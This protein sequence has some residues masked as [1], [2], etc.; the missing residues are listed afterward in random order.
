MAHCSGLFSFQMMNSGTGSYALGFFIVPMGEEL[1]ISRKKVLSN[2]PFQVSHNPHITNTRYDGRPKIRCTTHSYKR[3]SVRWAGS[4]SH[5]PN[6]YGLAVLHN[7][8]NSIRPRYISNGAQLIGP[9]LIS[10][11]FINMRGRAMAIGTMGISAGGVVIAPLAGVTGFPCSDGE[12][13]G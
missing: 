10:K 5:I 6:K 4:S 2:T 7:L 1:E 8:R 12:H 3:N 9:S 11:W 13:L